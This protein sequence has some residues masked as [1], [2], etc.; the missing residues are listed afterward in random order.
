MNASH[1]SECMSHFLTSLNKDTGLCPI[2]H[3]MLLAGRVSNILASCWHNSEMSPLLA[4]TAHTGR[5][6]V[7]IKSGCNILCQKVLTLLFLARTQTTTP[8]FHAPLFSCRC[9]SAAT[10]LQGRL[11]YSC[12][13]THPKGYG[14]C[15][16]SF[17]I[18][19]EIMNLIRSA[20]TPSTSNASGQRQ[21]IGC[22]SSA[23]STNSSRPHY[24]CLWLAANHA[25]KTQAIVFS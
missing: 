7:H 12:R 14:S 2:E 3:P 6:V 10:T 17:W 19:W 22:G 16:C 24:L 11:H 9:C 18:W 4:S 1:P 13:Q 25:P 5:W 23:W 15:Y 21:C 8:S 20:G